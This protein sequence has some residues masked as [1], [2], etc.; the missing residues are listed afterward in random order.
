MYITNEPEI[1][2]IAERSGVDRIF[3]D[4]ETLGKEK[5]Q[6]GLDT[7][8]SQHEISDI[9][10]VKAV[11][12]SSGLL[13]RVNSIYEKSNEEIDSVIKAG[14]DI[15]MLPYFKTSDEVRRFL[16]YVNQRARTCLL[17][18]TPE[19]VEHL[20][21]IISLPGIDEVHIGLNDL[22][23]GYKLDFM[24]ELLTN[25]TVEKI[26]DRIKPYGIPY[27]F[28]GIAAIGKGIV[29]SEYIIGEHYRLGSGMAIL[30]RS[31]CDISSFELYP[32][33][34]RLEIVNELFVEGVK[35]IRDLEDSLKNKPARFFEVNRIITEETINRAVP[36]IKAGKK[37]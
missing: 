12:S 23:L 3:I 10:A 26:I 20:E 29:P 36:I 24:F 13:V 37:N 1:A 8:K 21:E 11:L 25:G 14:A 34:T 4:L 19:A 9:P 6:K 16:E 35:K 2:Q 22:H 18:E 33:D 15:V 30:S 28:G 32:K 17:I 7:V 31:F 27:G 5:R